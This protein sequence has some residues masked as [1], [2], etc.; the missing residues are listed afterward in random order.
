MYEVEAHSD[1]QTFKKCWE[2]ALK[3][4]ELVKEG[5][6]FFCYTLYSSLLIPSLVV[7]L[8]WG[9]VGGFVHGFFAGFTMVSFSWQLVVFVGVTED[10]FVVSETER[11][12]VDGARVKVGIRVSTLSLTS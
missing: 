2:N 10:Q 8:P 5:G 11:I 3:G 9:L 12:P 1:Y 6:P 7:N 4:A